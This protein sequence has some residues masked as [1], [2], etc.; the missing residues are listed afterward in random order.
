[1]MVRMDEESR[2]GKTLA[3]RSSDY[4]TARLQL[5]TVYEK[6]QCILFVENCSKELSLHKP[7]TGATTIM[8][9]KLLESTL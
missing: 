2:N 4:T 9:N 5:V 6:H 1:M 8:K 7:I 3:T